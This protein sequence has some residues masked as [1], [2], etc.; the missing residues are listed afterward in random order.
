VLIDGT[1]QVRFGPPDKPA[2]LALGYATYGDD[3]GHQ[4]SSITDGAFAANDEALANYGGNSLKKTRDV[5]MTLLTLRYA[6][7]RRS[8]TSSAPPPAGATPHG[9]PALARGLRRRDRQRA[10]A[11]LQRHAPAQRRGRA[12]PLQQRRR[13][14]DERGQDL[15]GAAHRAGGLRPPGRRHDGI[16]SNVESCRQLNTQ[17]L[18]SLRCAGGADLGDTCLSDAQLDTV[19]TIESPLNFSNYAL[20]H[21][22]PR[23]AA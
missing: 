1:E 9:D 18:A 4:S 10:G 12:R 3:G 2:P 6:R 5:A 16:V 11:E 7:A 15:A 19:R 14:L 8:P 23:P 22:P 21:T 20:A 13:R 17:V